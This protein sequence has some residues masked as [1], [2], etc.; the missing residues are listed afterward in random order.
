MSERPANLFITGLEQFIKEVKCSV[1]MPATIAS[2][3]TVAS[4]S[5]VLHRGSEMVWNL[6]QLDPLCIKQS[7]RLTAMLL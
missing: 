1:P 4:L 7:S 5:G 3:S 2:H 6:K